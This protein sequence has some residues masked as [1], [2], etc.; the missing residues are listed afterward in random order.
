[1]GEGEGC[2]GRKSRSKAQ[3]KDE[4]GWQKEDRCG[5]EGE[6]GEGQSGWTQVSL[7]S[8]LC[9]VRGLLTVDQRSRVLS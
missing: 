1:M 6:M 3:A 4:C 5:S 9:A 7:M 2:E 8:L